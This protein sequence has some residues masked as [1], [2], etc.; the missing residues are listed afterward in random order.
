MKYLP[1]AIASDD[2]AI[3]QAPYFGGEFAVY[4][5][6][7]PAVLLGVITFTAANTATYAANA[8]AVLAAAG[9]VQMAALTAL[10]STVDL[11]VNLTGTNNAAAP[12]TGLSVFSA[13]S[14][15]G[16]PG[17]SYGRGYAKDVTISAG[18]GFAAIT[19]LSGVTGGA[20][21][22]KIGVFSL[23]V[24]AD[25]VLVGCCTEKDFNT[26]SRV[27]KGVDCGMESDA[28]VKR[29][30]SQPGDLNIS[31]KLFGFG[32]GLA[33]FD[34]HKTTA[35][36]VGLKDGQVLG[37]RLVFTEFTP[38]VKV[39]APDG[40]GEAMLDGNGKFVEHLFFVAP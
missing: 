28:F 14:Y 11:R 35:M 33:R 34:G 39:K 29:G 24:Q 17:S 15:A 3:A 7:V 4:L 32:D 21:G 9:D 13:P 23:P 6:H 26:K 5:T 30:K 31:N 40:D 8:G 38:T 36:L 25:Y 2:L 20:A 19:G 10:K 22:L 12:V 37:D 16:T 1:D 27:A 18:T